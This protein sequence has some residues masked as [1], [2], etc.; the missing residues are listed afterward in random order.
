M[1]LNIKKLANE[2][3]IFENFT[4]SGDWTVPC[5]DALH[6]GYSPENTLSAFRSDPYLQLFNRNYLKK[7]AGGK[8]IHKFLNLKMPAVTAL[9]NPNSRQPENMLTNVL[10]RNGVKCVGVKGSDNHSWRYGMSP[11]LVYSIENCSQ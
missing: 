3:T 1:N 10:E 6:T 11:G 8:T 4:S 2:S 5:L 7:L 9:S